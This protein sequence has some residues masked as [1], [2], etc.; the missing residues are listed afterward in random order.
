MSNHRPTDY[1][2]SFMDTTFFFLHICGPFFVSWFFD[3]IFFFHQK[4]IN[5]PSYPRGENWRWNHFPL[6]NLVRVNIKNIELIHMFVCVCVRGVNRAYAIG[7][8]ILA[9]NCGTRTNIKH[10]HITENWQHLA[11]VWQE[12]RIQ[13]E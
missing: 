12:A 1:G 9:L 13:I 8:H 3:F 2:K 5:N 4:A 6:I 10:M 11:S 7:V